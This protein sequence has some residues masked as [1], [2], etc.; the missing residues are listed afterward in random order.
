[1]IEY[2]PYHSAKFHFN[3]RVPSQQFSFDLVNQAFKRDAIVIQMRSKRQWIE[4]VPA[5]QNY[6]HYFT[7]NNPQ[8]VTISMGNCPVG[9]QAIID[10]FEA[11]NLNLMQRSTT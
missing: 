9:Y 8:N 5:L 7:L 10:H 6:Q 4:A 1:V 3:G 11:K 2:F